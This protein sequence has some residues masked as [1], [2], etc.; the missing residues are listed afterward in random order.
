MNWPTTGTAYRVRTAFYWSPLEACFSSPSTRKRTSALCARVLFRTCSHT[1]AS[2][3]FQKSTIRFNWPHA[4]THNYFS[5]GFSCSSSR[6]CVSVAVLSHHAYITRW[7]MYKTTLHLPRCTIVQKYIK[8]R[9]VILSY[10]NIR[11]WKGRA[12]QVMWNTQEGYVWKSC[13]SCN[14]LIGENGRN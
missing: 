4:V 3:F 11:S 9:C 13:R 1:V 2:S 10:E 14:I 6:L 12:L 7:Y 8:K 5:A